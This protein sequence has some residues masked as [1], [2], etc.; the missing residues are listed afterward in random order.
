MTE[1]QTPPPTQEDR[2][3]MIEHLT[4][5]LGSREEALHH[6]DA[7]SAMLMRENDEWMRTKYQRDRQ[8]AYVEQGA[9]IEALVVAQQEA[10]EGDDTELERIKSIRAKVKRQFPKP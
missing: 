8:Q 2:E 4:E 9:T 7:F 10:L 5:M 6:V 3:E 1:F